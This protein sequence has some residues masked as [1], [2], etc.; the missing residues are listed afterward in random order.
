MSGLHLMTLA[1]WVLTGAFALLATGLDNLKATSMTHG[2]FNMRPAYANFQ[3]GVRTGCG[4]GS[5][6]MSCELCSVKCV[7]A[8]L[9]GHVG[10]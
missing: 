3:L 4:S 1:R 10:M 7:K 8:A 9:R 5:L 6:N 2:G